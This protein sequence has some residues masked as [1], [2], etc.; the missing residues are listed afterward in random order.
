MYKAKKVSLIL[1]TYNEEES[2]TRVILNFQKVGVIDEIIVVDNNSKDS[3]IKLAKVIKMVRVIKEKKQGYGFALRK[4]FQK[5]SG[6]LIVLCDADNTYKASDLKKL[7]VMSHKYD[8]VFATRTD[9]KLSKGSNM[10]WLRRNANIIVGRMIQILF[11]GPKMTDPGATFRLLNR[12]ALKI[13]EPY[14]SVGGGHFQ[15]EL[16]TLGLLH[17][18]KIVEVPVY[19]GSRTGESKISGP[20]IGGIK[21]AK[22]MIAVI[23]HHRLVSLLGKERLHNNLLERGDKKA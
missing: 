8:F 19:Y 5:A 14:F 23:I 13:I 16:T 17:N 2:I 20:L 4:G 21:T 11:A 3:T 7:L 1:P 18:F 15:P 6:D 10:D 9:K 22:A 12:N